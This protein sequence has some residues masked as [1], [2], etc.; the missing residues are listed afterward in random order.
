MG[1]TQPTFSEA[2]TQAHDPAA[3]REQRGAILRRFRSGLEAQMRP[4]FNLPLSLRIDE[5]VQQ[6]EALSQDEECRP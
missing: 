5:L 1:L 2:G 3:E 4:D 6:E